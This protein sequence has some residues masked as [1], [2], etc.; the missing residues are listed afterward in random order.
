MARA[1]Q[2]LETR[3]PP[4]LLTILFADLMLFFAE[5]NTLPITRSLYTSALAI[6]CLCG[7]VVLLGFS[8]KALHQAKTTLDPHHPEHSTRLVQEGVYRFTRNPIYVAF[9]LLLLAW[10]FLLADLLALVSVYLFVMYMNR[11]QIEPEETALEAHFGTDYLLYCARV[12]RWLF[13]SRKTP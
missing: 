11:F 12:N 6:I 1:I 13:H 5:L 2:R 4:L 9:L 8:L 10:G 3:I 7:S